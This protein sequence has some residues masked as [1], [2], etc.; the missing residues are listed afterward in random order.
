MHPMDGGSLYK[1]TGSL[2]E[3]LVHDASYWHSM[4]LEH[5]E[6]KGNKE[7]TASISVLRVSSP[8]LQTEKVNIYQIS[9]YSS[10]QYRNVE[11]LKR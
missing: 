9:L 5:L 2:G 1:D 10:Y 4:T 11:V 6:P 7:N 3:K 8:Y